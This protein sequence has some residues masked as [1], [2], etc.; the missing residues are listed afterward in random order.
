MAV[1]AAFLQHNNSWG[2]LCPIQAVFRQQ[3][4]PQQ[5]IKPTKLHRDFAAYANDYV[6]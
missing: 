1:Y 2:G 3:S 6:A 5:R 4:P